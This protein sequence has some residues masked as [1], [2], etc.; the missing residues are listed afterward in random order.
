MITFKLFQV[1]RNTRVI[2]RGYFTLT[3]EASIFLLSTQWF[4]AVLNLLPLQSYK[5]SMTHFLTINIMTYQNRIQYD[6]I[7][8]CTSI[9]IN[10]V[11]NDKTEQPFRRSFDHCRILL[12]KSFSLIA[13]HISFP[14]G[15]IIFI[16]FGYFFRQFCYTFI[17]LVLVVLL[18]LIGE[19]SSLL[20]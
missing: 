18:S 12:R 14:R 16:L 10:N 13:F 17:Y 6:F 7:G 2:V 5:F 4:M 8:V 1:S 15:H 9:D 3:H 20:Q 11:T 19:M